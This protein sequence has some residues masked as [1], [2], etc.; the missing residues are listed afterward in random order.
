MQ[1]NIQTNDEFR[2]M[3]NN[4]KNNNQSFIALEVLLVFTVF[5]EKVY[6]CSFRYFTFYLFF[7]FVFIFLIY[8]F[9]FLELIIHGL[10]LF[11]ISPLVRQVTTLSPSEDS[12]QC[13]LLPSFVCCSI[14]FVYVQLL[15]RTLFLSTLVQ[16]FRKLKLYKRLF[17][18]C[19]YC[20]VTEL[21]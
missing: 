19:F 12:F 18:D 6:F 11:S 16:S 21:L 2:Y 1:Y 14:V 5:T 13:V 4:Y 8:L 3:W 17:V 20:N 15:L 9:F 7:F 10:F